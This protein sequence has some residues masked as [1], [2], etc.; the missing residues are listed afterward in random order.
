MLL[1]PN[2]NLNHNPNPTNPDL[3]TW[4]I[5]SRTQSR[6]PFRITQVNDQCGL[7]LRAASD[8]CGGGLRRGS[9]LVTDQSNDKDDDEGDEAS[10]DGGR[11]ARR[12]RGRTQLVRVS[13][14]EDVQLVVE[15][16]AVFAVTVAGGHVQ[17]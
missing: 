12:R 3:K 17:S 7:G 4:Q 13:G 2:P 6:P 5:R 8:D 9:E 15:L 16:K 14:A 1:A 11:Q 10:S